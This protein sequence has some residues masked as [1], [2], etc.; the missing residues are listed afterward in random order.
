MPCIG[1]WIVKATLGKNGLLKNFEAKFY[2]FD[3]IENDW[4]NYVHTIP[5]Q[6]II[7]P[8]FE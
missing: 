7:R 6:K 8:I 4:K 2:I 5:E 1:G 3:E